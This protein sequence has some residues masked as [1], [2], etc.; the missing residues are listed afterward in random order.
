MRQSPRLERILLLPVHCCRPLEASCCSLSA[1]TPCRSPFYARR[2]TMAGHGRS[3]F[4][5]VCV[6][7]LVGV[8]VVSF[9]FW[10]PTTEQPSSSRTRL[11]R[12]LAEDFSAVHQG[13][14]RCRVPTTACFL[15]GQLPR[16]WK[17]VDNADLMR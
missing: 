14:F 6:A 9:S 8:A 4:Q 16:P 15:Q 10:D 2:A 13:G 7:A 11:S 1:A 17:T 5:I 12:V 3:F